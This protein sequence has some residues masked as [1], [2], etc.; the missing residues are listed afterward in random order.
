[1]NSSCKNKIQRNFITSNKD[2]GILMM[3]SCDNNQ[4]FKNTITKNGKYGLYIEESSYNKIKKNNF[5]E[6]KNSAFFELSFLNRWIKNYWDSFRILPKPIFG[7][8]KI[9]SNIISWI[10]I[11][12]RP[13]RIT[14]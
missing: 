3:N 5:I 9:G 10:N 4:I 1:M 14:L 2:Y 11:D 6:N 8:I 12:W 7:K 13:S